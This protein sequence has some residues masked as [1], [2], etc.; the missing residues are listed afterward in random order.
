MTTTTTTKSSETQLVFVPSPGMG[1]LVSTVEF[2]KLLIN[3]DH[4]I[5][6]TILVMKTPYDTVTSSYTNSLSS[7]QRLHVITLPQPQTNPDPN[8]SSS[9]ITTLI[10]SNKPHVR[11]H[12]S[13]L[14]LD[15]P[16][17]GAFVVDMFCTAMID[18]A[19]EFH[20]PAFVFFTSGVAFLGLV[21]HLH[22]LRERDNINVTELKD[23][24]TEF[25]I[26]SFANSV[27]AKAFPN[28]VLTKEWD[29]FFLAYA[30]GL[31]KAD[32]ILVNSFDELEPHAIQS[33]S[34]N[35]NNSIPLYPVGPILNI[36]DKEGDD[37]TDIIMKWLDEQPRC[38]VIFLCFGSMG[39]FDVDQVREIAR[40]LEASEARF[41]WSLRKPPQKGL[42]IMAPPSIYTAQE[43]VEVL[44]EGF[45]DRTAEIGRVIGWAPQA[46]VLAHKA[47]AGFVSHCG[48]NS[49]LE[50]IYF[51]VPVATWPLY[52]EQQTNAFEL[53][54][55][56]NMAVEITLEYRV[57]FKVG[58]SSVLSAEKIEKG[59][60]ELL[61][62]DEV[63][64]K[65]KEMSEKSRET[66]NQGGSSYSHL[67]RFIDYIVN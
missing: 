45:L 27:P 5:S 57:E 17:L 64:K 32:G 67:G 15:S 36:K 53:V 65:V 26:P 28:I 49:T 37:V 46:Q 55:E 22:T 33:F 52:A 60:R 39:S 3:R 1:H 13:K 35:N 4:R 6:V 18:V 25:V 43:L 29:P 20:V 50:S 40:A 61:Q 12:V 7:S 23:T 47:T 58:S 51:G 54:R 30:E 59:I 42:N 9:P 41:I 11:D 66:L 10:D 48:W 31:K 21:L 62:N 8:D 14:V 44:P 19:R 38:S 63:R 2:A 56:L 34:E 16:R 24:D